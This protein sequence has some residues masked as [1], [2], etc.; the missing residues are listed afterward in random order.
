MDAYVARQPIFDKDMQIYA[1][2]L[3]FCDGT[4]KYLPEM[5]GDI[6]TNQVLSNSVI[7]IGMNEIC[8]G[9]KSF[10]NFTANLLIKQV[11]LLLSKENV[12]V[13]ILEEVFAKQYGERCFKNC[14]IVDLT[15]A[16]AG[17]VDALQNC[18]DWVRNGKNRKGKA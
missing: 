6:A 12:V 4:D 15:F 11:P 17:A 16:C 8:G 2:E 1:Y 7:N 13:E 3:L 10:I 5:D 14:D 18:C 9:K